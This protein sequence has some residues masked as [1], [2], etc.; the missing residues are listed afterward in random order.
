MPAQDAKKKDSKPQPSKN[1]LF[2]AAMVKHFQNKFMPAGQ[3]CF[4]AHMNNFPKREF[5]VLWMLCKH[6]Q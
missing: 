4:Q 6:F 3:Q 5:N 2:R 1:E